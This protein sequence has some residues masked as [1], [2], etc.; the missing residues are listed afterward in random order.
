MTERE[1]GVYYFIIIVFA[2][3]S[4]YICVNNGS[5]M[6][7]NFPLKTLVNNRVDSKHHATLWVVWR[8]RW[9]ER[10]NVYFS[11]FRMLCFLMSNIWKETCV[12]VSMNLMEHERDCFRENVYIS[13]YVCFREN[14]YISVYV[15][16]VFYFVRKR[17]VCASMNVNVYIYIQLFCSCKQINQFW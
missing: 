7:Q 10:E 16:L 9:S 5:T 11:L 14:L 12:C 2:S 3:R 17:N 6:K 1:R 13:V 4:T 15:Y 8:D